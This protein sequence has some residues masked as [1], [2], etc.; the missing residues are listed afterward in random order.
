MANV[1]CA[2]QMIVRSD[3]QCISMTRTVAGCTDA[4]RRGLRRWLR[5]AKA[6]RAAPAAHAPPHVCCRGG[7]PTGRHQARRVVARLRDG[8]Q[9]QQRTAAVLQGAVGGGRGPRGAS[10][11]VLAPWHAA[12]VR[13]PPDAI[14]SGG[15]LHKRRRKTASKRSQPQSMRNPQGPSRACP[16]A[17][18]PLPNENTRRNTK[19]AKTQNIDRHL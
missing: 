10:E 1:N 12:A 5:R 13:R 11:C 2:F 7:R 9:P 17:V 16:S 14:V 15:R 4:V 6:R 19:R 8:R 3:L 18:T